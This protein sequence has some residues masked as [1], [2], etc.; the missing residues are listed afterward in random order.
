MENEN[1]KFP[2]NWTETKTSENL[3]LTHI[4]HEEKNQWRLDRWKKDDVDKILKKEGFT[5]KSSGRT[6]TIYY[7]EKD[8]L[9]EIDYEISGISEFDILINFETLQNWLLPNIAKI[10]TSEK[11]EIK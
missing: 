6:G 1:N 9:L 5:I 3:F 11:N 8:K 4:P 7:V 10:S 2:K